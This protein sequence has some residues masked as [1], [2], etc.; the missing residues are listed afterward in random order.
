MYPYAAVH[1]SHSLTQFQLSQ[2]NI[3]RCDEQ[4]NVVSIASCISIFKNLSYRT[5]QR[6]GPQDG[7]LGNPRRHLK[8]VVALCCLVADA[9]PC[10]Y[11]LSELNMVAF[12]TSTQSFQNVDPPGGAK[13]N[14]SRVFQGT[15]PAKF[16]A[17]FSIKVRGD[18]PLTPYHGNPVKVGSHQPSNPSARDH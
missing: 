9:P 17:Q 12:R 3:P 4:R 2:F 16:I 7:S 6:S 5:F 1:P 10:N 11:K 8:G 13:C 15:S 18:W 14:T